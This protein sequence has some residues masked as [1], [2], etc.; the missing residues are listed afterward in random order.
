MAPELEPI[1]AGF[2][3]SVELVGPRGAQLDA[4]VSL[5]PPPIVDELP[6]GGTPP[7]GE[8]VGRV[9]TLADALAWIDAHAFTALIEGED[10]TPVPGGQLYEDH[11]VYLTALIVTGAAGGGTQ[12]YP[13][14]PASVLDLQGRR[15]RPASLTVAR[16]PVF[17]A[18]AP[19]LP[20]ASERY[21]VVEIDDSLWLLDTLERCDGAGVCL[22]WA[23]VLVRRGD[24]FFGA[25]VPAS[26]IVTDDSWVGGPHER[27]FALIAS[28]RDR[29]GVGFALIEERGARREAPVGIRH[30]HADTTWPSAGV[31]VWG[32]EL[33]VT[34]AGRPA[35]QRQL[36]PP[37]PLSPAN[38][39]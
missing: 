3:L 6:R 36:Q 4:V 18:P 7:P 25:F 39:F 19:T 11:G 27:R 37:P 29:A 21:Q 10:A 17:A 24:R 32:E 35:L 9:D 5:R 12:P 26:L 15:W 14:P 38:E 30:V 8:L 33:T 34:I 22:R 1:D 20:P 28:H 13:W 2:W 16:A 23:R 31:E